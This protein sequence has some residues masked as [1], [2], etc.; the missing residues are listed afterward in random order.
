M[1][2]I[3]GRPQS[4]SARLGTAALLGAAG[5]WFL[6]APQ[7]VYAVV[8]WVIVGGLLLASLQ[9]ALVALQSRTE[10]QGARAAMGQATIFLLLALGAGLFLRPVISLLPVVAGI[11]LILY[12]LARVVDSRRNQQYV[13]VSP[14]PDMLYGILVVV[15]GIVL[16]FNPFGSVLLMVRVLGGLFVLM[17]AADIAGALRS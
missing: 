11:A 6:L 8:K 2:F 16:L 1:V 7:S 12:G 14:V 10:P 15:A 13:N 3:N 9:A 17:A 4:R 5:I